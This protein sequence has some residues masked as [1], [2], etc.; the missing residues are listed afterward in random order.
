MNPAQWRRIL[1]L[2]VAITVHNIPE[3]SFMGV[4]YCLMFMGV[5]YCLMLNKL[6]HK[7]LSI[8]MTKILDK[9]RNS[10]GSK[11]FIASLIQQV[12]IYMG[13]Q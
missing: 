13:I 7:Y 3:G 11:E 1:L 9:F 12:P 10:T 6:T 5:W 2:I 4:W 8:L